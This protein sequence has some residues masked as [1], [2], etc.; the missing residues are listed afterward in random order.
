MN[1]TIYLPM[2][3]ETVTRNK[4]D[5]GSIT[6]YVRKRIVTCISLEYCIINHLYSKTLMLLIG[7]VTIDKEIRNM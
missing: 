2:Y 3:G 5:C 7:Y 1:N 4:C 6:V